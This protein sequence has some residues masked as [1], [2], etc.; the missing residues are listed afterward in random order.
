VLYQ[1]FREGSTEQMKTARSYYEQFLSR[2]GSEPR[3]AK[4]VDDIKRRC[5]PGTGGGKGGKSRG[6]VKCVSGRLQN[7][8]DYLQAMKDMAEI[9]KMQK[10]AEQQQKELEAQ[11]PAAPPPEAAAPPAAEGAAPAAEG[12]KKPKEAGKEG[13]APEG[14]GGGKPKGKKPGK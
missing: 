13:A 12:D 6:S 5:K 3:Y 4:A 2:A 8:E 11:Q 10:Q 9:E 7:I 1:D 14:E